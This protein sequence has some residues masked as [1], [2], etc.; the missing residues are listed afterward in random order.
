MGFYIE[1]NKIQYVEKV[2]SPGT[3]RRINKHRN[4]AKKSDSIWV[5]FLE[6]GHNFG[7]DSKLIIIEEIGNCNRRK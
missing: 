6:P 3:K 4:D 2:E 5:D 7:R 1:C